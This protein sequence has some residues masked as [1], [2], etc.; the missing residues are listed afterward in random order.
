MDKQANEAWIKG[1]KAYFESFLSDKFVSFERGMRMS[2]PE[3]LQM[4]GSFKCDVKTWNIEDPQMAMINAD[5]YVMSYKGTF[6]G[7][8]SGPDGKAQKLPSPIRAASVYVREGDNWKGAF[9]SETLIID[10]EESAA[11]APANPEP[12]KRRKQKRGKTQGSCRCNARL[13]FSSGDFGSGQTDSECEYRCT[14]QGTH[15][16]LGSLQGEGR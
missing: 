2:R 13:A 8:C 9:H 4:I 5:T 10:P 14:C 12:K 1:D 15:R 6:D 16:R 7:S 11:A 3:L